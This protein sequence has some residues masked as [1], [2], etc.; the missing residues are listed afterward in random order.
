MT[1]NLVLA[2]AIGY[3]FEQIEFFVKSLRKFYNDKIVFLISNKEFFVGVGKISFIS[4]FS[5]DSSPQESF[6]SALK[7]AG[8]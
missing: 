1:D 4:I 5:S 3:K 7:I 6:G 8:L 2:A